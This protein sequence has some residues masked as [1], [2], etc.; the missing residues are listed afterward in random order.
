MEDSL[1]NIS[2]IGKATAERLKA[3]GLDS[4]QKLASL[5]PEDLIKLK[6]KGIGTAT[7][8]KYI[9]NAKK[10][11]EES[12]HKETLSE[13]SEQLKAVEIEQ[14]EVKELESEKIEIKQEIEKE[15]T[16]PEEIKKETAILE[17]IKEEEKEKIEEEK[18][19]EKVEEEV[20]EE[21]EE[22]IPEPFDQDVENLKVLLKQQAE[23]NIGTVGH[24][25]HGMIMS[26]RHLP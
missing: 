25:D 2:G 1:E 6:I 10:I 21:K 24:V 4:V 20:I 9:D 26:F 18:I 3:A 5:T 12:S 19:T 14:S 16:I 8:K 11:L 13:K 23:C 17:E 22:E 7:A 15:E